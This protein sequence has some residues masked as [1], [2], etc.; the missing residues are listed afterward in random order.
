MN[1]GLVV[2][3]N[4]IDYGM[5]TYDSCSLCQLCLDAVTYYS[6]PVNQYSSYSIIR[7]PSLTFHE[8]LTNNNNYY[9]YYYYNYYYSHYNSNNSSK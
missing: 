2:Q 3:N 5:I 6:I 7:I 8:Q 4:S 9:Y 1:S